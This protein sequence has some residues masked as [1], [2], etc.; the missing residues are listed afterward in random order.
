MATINYAD[1]VA[2][3]VN[4]NIPEIN[5]VTD[6]NMNLI[7][8]VGNQIL[9]TMGVY[10]DDWNS[11]TTYAIG[12]IVIYDNRIFRNLT[13]T[14]T[15]TTPDQDTTNW[16]ETTI[17]AMAGG[18]EIPIQNTAPSNPQTDDLWIDTSEPEEMQEA[19][20]NE[21]SK[22]TS[23]TYSCNYVNKIGQP[24]AFFGDVA[25]DENN[26]YEVQ[27]PSKVV[28]TKISTDGIWKFE[29]QGIFTH[30]S[31]SVNYFRWGFMPSKI[32]DLLNT[33]IGVQVEYDDTLRSA[34]NYQLYT[35]SGGYDYSHNGYGTLFEWTGTYLLFARH[36]NTS[37]ASGG[38]TL[39]SIATGQAITATIY[40]RE[41]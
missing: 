23:D 1:K 3:N 17:A 35:T 6:G 28:A 31:G 33:K 18:A 19:I 39:D 2:I 11:S 32:S 8:Q 15:E 5:K 16:E 14:N 37:G 41:V 7:K 30:L 36:Y 21:Y 26:T 20:V 12:D 27:C 38:W 13:G 25:G 4:P 34:G 22:S 9:T 40:L 10:T 29:I 24:V